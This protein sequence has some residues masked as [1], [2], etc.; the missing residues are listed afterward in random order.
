MRFYHHTI[1]TTFSLLARDHHLYFPEFKKYACHF[2]KSTTNLLKIYSHSTKN[3][4][5]MSNSEETLESKIEHHIEHLRIL[6][7][8]VAN[9]D[10]STEKSMKNIVQSIQDIDKCIKI[11][12]LAG[13]NGTCGLENNLDINTKIPLHV[14]A[15][16]DQ[17]KSPLLFTKD[18]V[19]KAIH[20][21]EQVNGQIKVMGKFRERL[22]N[23][24]SSYYPD[25]MKE[26]V[27]NCEKL[28]QENK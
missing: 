8:Q 13:K 2:R 22:I 17:G 28:Y 9:A 26:Y 5:K 20:K 24:L 4:N 3:F 19:E 12:G 7:I 21:N 14:L 10:G 1:C 11:T 23:K 27:G 15:Y 6:G 16:I 25:E 18:A